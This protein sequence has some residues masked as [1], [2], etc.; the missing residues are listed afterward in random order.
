MMDRPRARGEYPTNRI[1]PLRLNQE[2]P[3]SVIVF[4]PVQDT[5]TLQRHAHSRQNSESRGLLGS[6]SKNLFEYSATTRLN[7]G[8]PEPQDVS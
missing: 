2:D 6:P 4:S 8:E 3:D 1:R 5:P 7:F